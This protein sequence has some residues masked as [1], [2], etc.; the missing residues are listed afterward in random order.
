MQKKRHKISPNNESH[1]WERIGEQKLK[2][3]D[4][5]KKEIKKKHVKNVPKKKMMPQKKSRK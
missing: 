5:K 4:A 1:T 2:E 3:K